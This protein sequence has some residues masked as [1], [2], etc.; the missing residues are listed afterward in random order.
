MLL[1]R[2]A[3]I[4]YL[5]KSMSAYVLTSRAHGSL[6]GSHQAPC[7][8]PTV[9]TRAMLIVHCAAPLFNLLEEFFTL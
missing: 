3:S 2:E 4:S 6:Q 8:L 9:Q 5:L 7:D 1:R